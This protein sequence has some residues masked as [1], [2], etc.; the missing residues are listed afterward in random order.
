M[1]IQHTHHGSNPVMFMSEY[2]RGSD[3]WLD[4]IDSYSLQLQVAIIFMGLY[5]LQFTMAYTWSS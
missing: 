2:R 3:W 5:S 1:C 4:V